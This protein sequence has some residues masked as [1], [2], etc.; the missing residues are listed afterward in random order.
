MSPARR[1]ISAGRPRAFDH[2]QV[3]LLGQPA[4][5]V[6]AGRQKLRFQGGIFPGAHGGHALALH[7]NL[8]AAVGFGFQQDRVHIDHGVHPAGQGL[9]RLRTSDFPPVGGNGGVV[10]HIL[11]FEGPHPQTAPRPQAAQTRDEDRLAYVGSRALDHYSMCHSRQL[12]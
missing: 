1:L 9:K 4:K 6:D 11:R 10:G 12:R 5:A 2:D 8:T 3:G 7:D